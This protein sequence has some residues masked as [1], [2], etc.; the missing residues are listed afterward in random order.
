MPSQ[1][2]TV[3]IRWGDKK[4]EMD[5]VP[6]H[7]YIDAVQILASDKNLTGPGVS[8]FLESKDPDAVQRFQNAAR[9]HQWNVFVDAYFQDFSDVLHQG[10]RG[11]PK[12]SKRLQ[13]RPGLVALESV[14]AALKGQQF[15]LDHR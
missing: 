6:I 10:A 11:N 13:G 2:I 14:F 12:M 4:Y 1:L 8:I 9:A 5:L 15:C 3:H 7:E